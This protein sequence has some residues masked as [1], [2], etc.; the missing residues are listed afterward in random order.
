VASANGRPSIVSPEGST[1]PR[2]YPI[3]TLM[4]GNP[5][6]GE[7]ELTVVAVRA[8]EVADQSRRVA[9]GRVHERIETGSIHELHDGLPQL[10]AKLVP[11]PTGRRVLGSLLDSLTGFEPWLDRGW[12]RRNLTISSSVLSGS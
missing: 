2:K 6:L 4:A 1:P 12:N 5:V 10:R 11:A 9:P 8:V 7:K 3:G